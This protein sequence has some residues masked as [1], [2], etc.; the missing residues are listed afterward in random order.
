MNSEEH[1][2]HEWEQSRLIL[3]HV[4]TNIDSANILGNLRDLIEV[5]ILRHRRLFVAT[6]LSLQCENDKDSAFA[7]L[8]KLIDHYLPSIGFLTGREC[9]LRLIDAV[10]R[11]DKKVYFNMASLLSFLIIDE[12]ID[13]GTAFALIY[14]L[15]RNKTDD[16]II[17]ICH[18]LC[19][20]GQQLQAFDKESEADIAEKLRLIYQD[21]YTQKHT[22]K[23]L[24]RLFDTR[25]LSYRNV[26]K[27]VNIPTVE[28]NVHE[29]VVDFSN[30]HPAMDL[31]GFH[32]DDKY[33]LI[34]EQYEEIKSEI[35]KELLES[36]DVK[37]SLNDMTDS[38][39]TEFKKKVYLILKGS[40]SGD[41]AAHK[42]LQL[43]LNDAKK[44]EVADTITKACAQEP[45]YSKFYGIL[46]ERLTSFH[47]SWQHSFS[48]VF[49]ENY[50]TI[51]DNDP[52]NIRNLG[53]FWGHALATECIPFEVFEIVHMNERDSNAANRVFLKFLFQEMVV[54]LGIDALK[55]KL[56]AVELQPFLSN[57]FP[58]EAQDDIM[59]SIN[60]FTAIGLGALTD[61]MRN[62]LQQAE[63]EQR[64]RYSNAI[65][66]SEVSERDNPRVPRMHPDR[67]RRNRSR[68]P[69]SRRNR[70]R[71]P[72]RRRQ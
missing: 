70:S 71:T 25:R 58:R 2:Q 59:F 44:N 48:A 64:K 20:L 15:L 29:V 68:S 62:I 31:D 32:L 47:V 56:E 36:K 45:T 69:I 16:N 65:K 8:V 1:Q 41:E 30:D 21:R 38:E 19:L 46:T 53:K 55:K 13:E 51:A 66:N 23:A 35:I 60:Y 5:N 14:F 9:V 40:L 18:F 26:I 39:N 61:N 11:S 10:Y 33:E 24:N 27:N 49:K 43:R 52:S 54:N 22:Y 3:S 34:N 17:L 4:L 57:L 50:Q 6:L 7:G 28:N 72:P 63:E 67:L 42:L 12:V 37:N